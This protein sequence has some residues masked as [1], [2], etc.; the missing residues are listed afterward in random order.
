[1]ILD[2]YSRFIVGWMV[3][4]KESKALATKLIRETCSKHEIAEGTLTIHADRGSSMTSKP[5]AL[6]CADLGILETHSRPYQ[7]NDNP[8]SESNFKTLKY[9]PDFP[10]S[11][12][13]IEDARAF[14]RAFVDWYN[15]QHHHSGLA[16]FTPHD[17][18][19]GLVEDKLALPV[20][21]LREAYELH[22]ERFPKG[23]P[24]VHRRPAEVWINKRDTDPAGILM[25]PG[26]H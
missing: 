21:T 4:H 3:A 9:R 26:A 20:A 5:V 11:F 8:Y 25:P 13:S 16:M 18:H 23:P 15:L 17:V 1:V 7:S 6:L 2:V 22:P 24:A 12:G 10:P 14:I 19:Y